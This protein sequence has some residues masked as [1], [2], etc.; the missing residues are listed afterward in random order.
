MKSEAEKTASQLKMTMWL[1]GI[2]K[3]LCAKYPCML[4]FVEVLKSDY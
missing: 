1:G 3:W 2:F 4:C